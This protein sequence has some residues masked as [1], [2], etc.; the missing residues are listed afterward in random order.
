MGCQPRKRGERL[1]NLQSIFDTGADLRVTRRPMLGVLGNDFNEKIATQI[2]VPVTEGY[3]L[4]DVVAGMGAEKA[5][6]QGDDVIVEMDGAPVRT[7]EDLGPALDRRQAGDEIEVVFY[8]GPEKN[9][10]QMVLSGR[11][12]TDTPLDPAEFAQEYRKITKEV[13]EELRAAVE[14][15]SEASRSR[16]KRR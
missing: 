13:L 3:R 5:G 15:A 6:L 16:C 9:A 1:G 7:W 12:I 11:T 10:V 14:G 8:R 4:A 2:G